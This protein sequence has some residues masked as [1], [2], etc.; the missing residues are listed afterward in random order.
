MRRSSIDE[1]DARLESSV[2]DSRRLLWRRRIAEVVGAE[3]QRGD[4]NAGPSQY[5]VVQD[6]TLL[7]ARVYRRRAR[8]RE[9]RTPRLEELPQRIN[10]IRSLRG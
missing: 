10:R 2:E 4:S 8:E 6:E 5:P 1:V 3:T 9:T 7:G